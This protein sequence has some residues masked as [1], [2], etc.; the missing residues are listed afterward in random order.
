MPDFYPEEGAVLAEIRK[1]LEP[2]TPRNKK[3]WELVKKLVCEVYPNW[4]GGKE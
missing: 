1:T 3:I 2:M 4:K